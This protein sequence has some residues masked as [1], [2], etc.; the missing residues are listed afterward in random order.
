MEQKS[1]WQHFVDVLTKDYAN[2]NGRARRREFWGFALFSILISGVLSSIDSIIFDVPYGENG[3]LSS[4]FSLGTL[5]PSLAVA[6]RRLHDIGKS[7]WMQ[8]LWFFI[9][10]GWIWL[11]VLYVTDSHE[12]TNEY[13]PNPKK[14]NDEIAEIGTE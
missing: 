5:V 3:I 8:L 2:F 4:I 13:G 6:T 9:L 11:L 12:D 14:P 7:G 1:L 10:I